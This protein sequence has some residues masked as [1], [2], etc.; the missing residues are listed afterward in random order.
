MPKSLSNAYVIGSTLRVTYA[1][2]VV[3]GLVLTLHYVGTFIGLI[4]YRRDVVDG[5]LIRYMHANGASLFLFL[6]FA[7]VARRVYYNSSNKKH[8]WVSRVVILLLSMGAAFLG[9]V[10]PYRQMS[11]WGATVIINLVSVFSSFLVVLL[12]GRW[13]V[14][15]YTL[16]RFYTL[17]FLLPLALGALVG[18]HLLLLHKTRRSSLSYSWVKV[19]FFS[20][21]FVKDLFM[22]ALAGTIFYAIVFLAPNLLGDAENYIAANSMV[23]PVH[24]KPEWYFLFAYGILRCIPNKAM[25]VLALVAAVALPVIYVIRSSTVTI[26][27]FSLIASSFSLLTVCGRMPVA[28]S[29]YHS[30]QALSESYF[31]LMVRLA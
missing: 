8:L 5:T 18:G 15:E 16:T 31:T 30:S 9:Y 2:Q 13:V 10:L 17:H 23:T 22:W 26:V 3:S 6:M 25:G 29:I 1:L 27:T 19:G 12:W 28:T 20:L 11:Y 7:H 21:Y 24:I 4:E 14:S